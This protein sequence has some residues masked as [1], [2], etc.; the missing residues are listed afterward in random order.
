MRTPL[1]LICLA[2]A[3]AV[4]AAPTPE[5]HAQALLDA[6]RDA[7]A[8]PGMSAAIWQG[9]RMRWQG[10]SGWR[11][12]E[13]QLPVQAGTRFR[14]ASVSKLFAVTMAAQLRA[15]G[16]L[17]A[18]QPVGALLPGLDTAIA[19][20]TPRQ[21][22][23]HLSGMPHYEWRDVTRG[24]THH[25]KARDALVHMKGRELVATPGSRYLYSSWGYTLL[26]AAA[27]AAA[28]QP[29]LDRLHSRVAPG[30]D[31]GPDETGTS[32]TMSGAYEYANGGVQPAPAH[33]FSYSWG[34]AGLAASA[35]ALAEWGSRV[36]Q[37]RVVD[38]ATRDW[39]W[40]PTLNN[41]GQPVTS[42][43][44][45]LGF[46]WRL[47]VDAQGLRIVHHAGSALGAR[48]VLLLWPQAD[49]SVSLLSNVMWTSSIERSAE[50]LSAPFRAPLPD[51]PP[52]AC[53]VKTTGFDAELDGAPLQGRARFR[54]DEDGLCR[55]E[56]GLPAVLAKVVNQG[57]QPP[58]DQ[59][60]VIG[61]QGGLARA[62]L[63]SP[64]GL[65]DWQAQADGSF[66]VDGVAGRKL[67]VRLTP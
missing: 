47:G 60:V 23:A 52:R 51:L 28:G 48:S 42:G 63:A 26:G 14:L 11:D 19:A 12:V 13:H 37:G 41:A 49:T 44:S 66:R 58:A 31:I 43:N 20:L 46:G 67:V 15:E 36:L 9:G 4:A 21:L 29:Y 1:T 39:M 40:Q 45:T 17:D 33:D 62:A 38:A 2:A 22:A 6:M 50:L 61:L 8:V 56:L 65:S 24:H 35:P 5:R 57:P 7:A 55:G 10:S 64:I 16:K 54:V 30:L 27:E 34:G 32:A 3:Q 59:L 18:D 25:A 53:P